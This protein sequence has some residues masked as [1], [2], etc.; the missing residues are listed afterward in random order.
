MDEWIPILLAFSFPLFCEKLHWNKEWSQITVERLWHFNFS[1]C[2]QAPEAIYN[3]KSLI[4]FTDWQENSSNV[5]FMS[6]GLPSDFT[7]NKTSPLLF[8]QKAMEQ[9][10]VITALGIFYFKLSVVL[11]SFYA[12]F[13][14]A[15]CAYRDNWKSFT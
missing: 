9:R 6:T 10:N 3:P 13:C 8:K 11:C 1:L 2:L 5:I 12:H 14:T 7:L 15:H 4:F